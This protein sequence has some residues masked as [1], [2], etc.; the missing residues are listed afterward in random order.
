MNTDFKIIKFY[1]IER[2]D[3]KAFLSGTLHIRLSIG[4]DLKGIFIH[5]K[6]DFLFCSLPN[7]KGYD[8]STSNVISYATFVFEDKKLN[9]EFI[10]NLRDEAKKFI[11]QYLLENPE[12]LPPI[13]KANLKQPVIHQKKTAEPALVK[14]KS[15]TAHVFSDLQENATETKKTPLIGDAA[16]NVTEIAEI[17]TKPKL[18]PKQWIDPPSRKPSLKKVRNKIV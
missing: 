3:K 18:K 4:I 2:D 9:N 10:A 16:S 8:R 14:E 11:E 17:V 6:K 12:P 1:E 5:K 15:E 13:P 7:R